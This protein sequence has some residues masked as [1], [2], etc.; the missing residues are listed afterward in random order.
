MTYLH[1]NKNDFYNLIQLASSDTNLSA[2]AIE[3]DY[4]ISLFLRLMS[5]KLDYI[6]FKGGTS[7][8]KC[9]GLINRFSED[10]D[11]TIDR[12]LTQGEKK[13]IKNSIIDVSNEL[14]LSIENID[15]IRSRRDY[16]RYVISYNSVI[17]EMSNYLNPAIILETS[18]ISVSYPINKIEVNNYIG[19]LLNKNN[20]ELESKF[21]LE[22]F[23]MKVQSTER[24]LIDKIFAICDYYLANKINR[25]SR[26]IYDIYK[27]LPAV[28]LNDDFKSL[29]KEVRNDRLNSPICLS[30]QS[31]ININN[32]LK[33]IVIND[34]YLEDYQNITL[35]LL[36][37]K[38]SY[39]E[40]ISSLETIIKSDIF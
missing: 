40:A 37:D 31:D 39:K 3:K 22:P 25:H 30:A 19:K 38:T 23:K 29:I 11:I 20:Q 35:Q 21:C 28:D 9:Y 6:V 10:I 24:T 18:Y 27:I 15:D 33:D 12:K 1:S 17:K 26:H 34:I 14:N 8:S 32:L 16:N 36:G 5:S 2:Q 4:Y 7:L 13:K